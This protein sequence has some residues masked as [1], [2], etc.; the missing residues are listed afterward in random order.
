MKEGKKKKM[1]TQRNGMS[2]STLLF[3]RP[4]LADRGA[5]EWNGWL[6]QIPIPISSC[7]CSWIG[8]GT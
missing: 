1:E 4:S 5:M 3:S 2:T 8:L 6:G 7:S